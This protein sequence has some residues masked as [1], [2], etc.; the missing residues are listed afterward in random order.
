MSALGD[1]R[2]SMRGANAVGVM[3]R[4]SDKVVLPE[5]S[6]RII[7]WF[8]DVYNEL[9]SG[10]LERVY[11]RALTNVLA[12]R[13]ISVQREVPL[14]V[15]FRG[16]TIGE[17]RADLIVEN[18]II[19]ECKAGDH[20]APQHSAQLLNYLKATSRPLGILLN[21]GAKPTFKRVVLTN[22]RR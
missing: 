3:L 5:L 1:G 17:Y 13:G 14:D 20:L 9:G 6:H 2:R 21:F 22:T 19:V 11:Q 12:S 10:F 8:Y 18:T 7:G 4:T 16:A 15:H